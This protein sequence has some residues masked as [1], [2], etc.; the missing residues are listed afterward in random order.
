MSGS[1]GPVLRRTIHSDR[2]LSLRHTLSPHRR[3]RSDPTH[4]ALPDGSIW[5]T[6][7][8]PS[9][10]V[11][12]RLRQPSRTEVVAD[13][14]G[15][16][17]EDFVATLP[18]LIGMLDDATGF[19][20]EHRILVEAARRLTHLH[21]G[22]TGQVFEA[23]V[24]AVLEQKVHGVAAFASWRR[25]VTRFGAPAPGPAPS[26]MAVSPPP[27][28]WRRIPSWEFHRANVDPKRARTIVEA[29]RVADKLTPIVGMT[30]DDAYR[31]LR[32]VP[33]IGEW[34][35]AEVCQRAL[36]DADALSV[37][38]YHLASVIGWSLVGAP[39]TDD[40]MV[41]YLEPLR[42]HRYRAVRLLE[43][44]GMAVRPKFGPRTA[45]T[46]HRFH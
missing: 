17:A 5:R 18:G 28:V 35:A 14:W 33:G 7:L 6:S 26:G 44:S 31:R 37:G 12:Y 23:L 16:G 3:G 32:L 40:E 42:P 13:V 9:G 43:V 22:R 19:A 45:I 2:P 8:F 15:D 24:P 11:T 25:L 1:D 27:D 46:D 34:T 39:M 29:A 30:H 21:L 38:D 10:A 41:A 36:G 20:P 4:R